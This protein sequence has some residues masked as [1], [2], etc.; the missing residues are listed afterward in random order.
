MRKSALLGSLSVAVVLCAILVAR[1]CTRCQR[2]LSLPLTGLVAY[3]SLLLLALRWSDRLPFRIALS[4]A[5]G[6]HLGLL[7]SMAG[8]GSWCPFCVGVASCCAV[9]VVAAFRKGDGH[10]IPAIAPWSAMAILSMLPAPPPASPVKVP[11]T[12]TIYSSADCPYCDRLRDEVLPRARAGIDVRVEYR[13]AGSA[14][15][16]ERTPTLVISRGGSTRV[17][18]GLPAPDTLRRE[19]L[20]MGGGL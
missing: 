19:L 16:V 7:V 9:A 18:E 14:D 15:F 5:A 4:A 17:L 11:L 8:R 12:L 20:S 2:G 3:G 1:D 10:L 13:D 6:V